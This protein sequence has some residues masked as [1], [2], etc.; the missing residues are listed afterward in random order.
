MILLQTY[1]G[2]NYHNNNVVV[3]YIKKSVSF[4]PIIAGNLI[5]YYWDFVLPLII[6]T[7]AITFILMLPVFV[8]SDR[9]PVEVFFPT[10]LFS[11]VF[12]LNFFR[13]NWRKNWY[14]KFQAS[15]YTM[16]GD[17]KFKKVNPEALINNQFIIPCFSNIMLEYKAYG[18]FAL[19]L[20]KIEIKNLY[21]DDSYNF[22]CFF[23]FTKK[24]TDGDLMIR[25]I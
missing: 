6:K 3:D 13:K 19:Y 20:K 5:K 2:D 14:P 11:L 10:F 25:Y 7:I 12:S 17:R 9:F 18:D 15:F 23:S 8:I 21:Q 16:M 4:E 1:N 24:V 22:F